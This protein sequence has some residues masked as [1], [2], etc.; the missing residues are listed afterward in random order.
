M[1]VKVLS[2]QHSEGTLH[3]A[4]SFRTVSNEV[5]KQLIDAGIAEEF[6][7]DVQPEKVQ[8]KKEEKEKKEINIGKIKNK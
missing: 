7:D 8:V 6:S 2:T 4:G 5:A 3:L 1:K